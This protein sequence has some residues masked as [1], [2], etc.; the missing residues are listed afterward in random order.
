MKLGKKNK[1]LLN[2]R[3]QPTIISEGVEIFGDLSCPVDVKID[4]LVVGNLFCKGRVVIGATGEV[5]GVIE[6]MEVLVQGTFNGKLNCAGS[7]SFASTAYANGEISYKNLAIENGAELVGEILRFDDES[8]G[9]LISELEKIN[10]V[11]TENTGNLKL[12]K[13]NMSSKVNPSHKKSH[14]AQDQEK[15]ALEKTGWS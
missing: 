2:V 9:N 6:A 3:V 5:V 10:T 1:E 7:L 8:M 11:R 12:I 4:G 15:S 14:I 13:N